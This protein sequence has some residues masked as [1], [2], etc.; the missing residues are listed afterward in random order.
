MPLRGFAYRTVYSK[1]S[2]FKDVCDHFYFEPQRQIIHDL[3]GFLG[4]V[5][6]ILMR[7]LDW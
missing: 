1:Q 3:G 7:Q 4:N 2:N 5:L 6:H